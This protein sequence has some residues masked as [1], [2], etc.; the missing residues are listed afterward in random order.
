MVGVRGQE[1]LKKEKP[2]E[3]P[4]G[5]KVNNRSARA[6]LVR[7]AKPCRRGTE[8]T[9]Q[10]FGIRPAESGWVDCAK[11]HEGC[12]VR[13]DVRHR[14]RNKTSEGKSQERIRNETS[15]RGSV[16]SKASRG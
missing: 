8:S 12:G 16:G 4:Q 15:P 11:R 9:I 1:A 3:V 14:V 13:E 7:C 2:K 5:A 10:F 6:G